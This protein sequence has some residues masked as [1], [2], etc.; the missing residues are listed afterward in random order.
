MHVPESSDDGKRFFQERY[1][2][3]QAM[4]W[5]SAVAF[6][7]RRLMRSGAQDAAT[8]RIQR[9]VFAR[10]L[11]HLDPAVVRRSLLGAE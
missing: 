3:S 8:R 6:R 7:A 4:L 11:G 10:A 2:R 9:M 1:E 5:A